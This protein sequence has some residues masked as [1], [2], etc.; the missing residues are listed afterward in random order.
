MKIE[1][2]HGK[3][4]SAKR[5]L[6]F[7][8]LFLLLL[9]ALLVYGGI[10]FHRIAQQSRM[11]E[12]RPADVIVV[13]GAAEYGG[14]PSPVYRARLE[15]AAEL[16]QRGLAPFIITSGGPGGE[17][18]FSEG[19]VGRDYLAAHG[20]PENQLIAETQSHDTNESAQR[21]AAIMRANGMKTCI[22][23]SDDY[24]L[25]RVKKMLEAQGV[26]V[27]GS[28]RAESRPVSAAQ[29]TKLVIQEIFKYIAWKLHLS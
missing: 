23:V 25:F 27:Y 18:T 11:D 8:R 24:H 14:R 15:H 6:S 21:V 3:P 26:T 16:F 22:A 17:I 7:F 9:A 1:P 12:A 5:R 4:T 28:P 20:V 2:G 19:Q 29:H 13:L 10:L